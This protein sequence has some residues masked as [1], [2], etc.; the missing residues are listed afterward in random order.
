[1]I[2][3]F[4]GL[5]VRQAKGRIARR[6]AERLVMRVIDD[7]RAGRTAVPPSS[8][9]AIVAA[10]RDA[11]GQLLDTH[12]AAVELLNVVRPSVAVTWYAVF[13]AHALHRHT[14]L[15]NELAA[16]DAASARN[17][18]AQ[19]IR[20]FYPFAPY[21]G[22]RVLHD[23]V[24]HDVHFRT[25]NLVLLDVYGTLHRREVWGDPETFRPQRWLDRIPSEFDL[26]PQGGGDPH[27]GHRCPGELVTITLLE[28]VI[29]CLVDDL[30]YA[31]PEQDTSF[32]LRRMP[33]APNSGMRLAALRPGSSA[34]RRRR[35]A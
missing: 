6:K 4:G 5:P 8:P 9:T 7:A 11:D 12:T 1:M 15:R 30:E 27:D 24:W 29:D 28:C 22:A 21:L 10:H 35:S 13:A 33:T 31:V 23:F 16:S 20:R 18:F 34:V 3:G 32:S 19:E 26:V 2:D 17:R 14:D 25:G